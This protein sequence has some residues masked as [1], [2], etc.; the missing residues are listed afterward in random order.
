MFSTS[1]KC[2]YTTLLNLKFVFFNENSNARKTKLNKF[3]LLTLILPIKKIQL[4]DFD[5]KLWQI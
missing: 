3:Y 4:F 2:I 5:I 1:P